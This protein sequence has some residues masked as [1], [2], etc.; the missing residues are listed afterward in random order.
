MCRRSWSSL[1]CCSL[2]IP[3]MMC[4][5]HL[6][7]CF[8]KSAV[9]CLLFLPDWLQLLS[10]T[11]PLFG[12]TVHA[13]RLSLPLSQ[14]QVKMPDDWD[15]FVKK[16][17]T[18]CNQGH[19]RSCQVKV[20]DGKDPYEQVPKQRRAPRSHNFSSSAY[21]SDWSPG[22]LIQGSGI[23][24]TPGADICTQPTLAKW[25]GDCYLPP[26]L[27]VTDE[28][29]GLC[30]CTSVPQESRGTTEIKNNYKLLNN[31]LNK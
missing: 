19:L 18:C 17:S 7:V 13:V 10:A 29:G 4:C 22:I 9:C 20:P 30:C 3:L 12:Q 25:E 31:Y 11:S 27:P 5:F 1:V 24:S 21:P 26:P 2:F 28:G 8:L 6:M 15:N 16:P 23:T 14:W